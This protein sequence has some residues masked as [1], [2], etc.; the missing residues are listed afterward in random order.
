MPVI[1]RK[2]LDTEMAL[3]INKHIQ[4]HIKKNLS[5][6]SDYETYPQRHAVAV[7]LTRI[8]NR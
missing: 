7:T 1:N 2:C 5:E 3:I 6:V 4:H 8:D